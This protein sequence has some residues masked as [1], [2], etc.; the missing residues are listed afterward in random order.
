MVPGTFGGRVKE[1]RNRKNWTQKKLAAT[2]GI[3][4]GYLSK[5]ESGKVAPPSEKVIRKMAKAFRAS[6]DELMILAGR[7]S[8]DPTD[9]LPQSA[10]VTRILRRA[11]GLT[12]QDWRKVDQFIRE[13]KMAKEDAERE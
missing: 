12:P 1:L 11:R 5:I 13:L 10:E 3:D 4:S 6:Q 7:M 9:P 8:S 2:I